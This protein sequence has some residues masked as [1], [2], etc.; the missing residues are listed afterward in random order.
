MAIT[1]VNYN[2][3][4]IILSKL[5]Q[6]NWHIAKIDTS[7]FATSEDVLIGIRAMADWAHTQ[8]GV[9][10]GHMTSPWFDPESGVWF[11]IKLGR[12]LELDLGCQFI[13]AFKDADDFL[14]YKLKWQSHLTK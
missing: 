3:D 8:L 6:D 7:T 2:K 10:Y 11:G 4:E 14:M 5:I 9:M 12:S 1:N 13:M